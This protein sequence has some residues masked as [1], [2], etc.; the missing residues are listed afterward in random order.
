MLHNVVFVW[1]FGIGATECRLYTK[2]CTFR[3][4]AEDEAGVGDTAAAGSTLTH[5]LTDIRVHARHLV[6][7]RRD[8]KGF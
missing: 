8:G 7:E 1:E 4:D 3:H 5:V 6:W 2:C